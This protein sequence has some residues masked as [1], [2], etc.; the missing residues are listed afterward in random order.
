MVITEQDPSTR[1]VI[2]TLLK[3]KK[4]MNVSELA[5]QLGITEMAVRRHLNTLERDGLV[6][7]SIVRQA[8]GRPSLM[9]RLT[10]EADNQFPKNY[11]HLVLE[12]LQELEELGDAS[13]ISEV[14]AGTSPVDRLFEGRKQK[15]LHKYAPRMAGKNLMERV[16]EL[17][18][19]QNANGYMVDWEQNDQGE[20]M[21][22]EHNCPITQVANAFNQACRCELSLFR[23]LLDASVERTE[24][25]AKGGTCCTY[26][27]HH[28]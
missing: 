1:R 10:E 27:I 12:L 18:E 17:A 22:Y 13:S 15:L 5:K 24:C 23:E 21:I 4:S 2:L 25:L 26:R 6:C 19:I 16:A 28:K 20:L 8:I 7:N 14:A 3:T 11:Q 9:Y